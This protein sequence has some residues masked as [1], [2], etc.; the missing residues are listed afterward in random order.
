MK[1]PLF[2]YNIFNFQCKKYTSPIGNKAVQEI[3]AGKQF[4]QADIAAVVSNSRYTSSAKQLANVTGVYLL[5]Y[6]ELKQF[7]KTIY[8]PKDYLASKWRIWN[9]L[10][11]FG[12]PSKLTAKDRDNPYKIKTITATVPFSVNWLAT[13]ISMAYTGYAVIPE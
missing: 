8:Q 5:H 9:S 13:G 7:N 2:I 3:I 4:V 12:A 1:C 11:M 6:S 10:R